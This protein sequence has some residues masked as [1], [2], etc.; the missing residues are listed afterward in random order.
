MSPRKTK[1]DVLDYLNEIFGSD[2]TDEFSLVIH[3][4]TNKSWGQL[5]ELVGD[6]QA[7]VSCDAPGQIK[8]T[9]DSVVRALFQNGK[10][11]YYTANMQYI[12]ASYAAHNP[13][14]CALVSNV[15]INLKV[16][17]N[18]ATGTPVLVEVT[19]G[20]Y[21]DFW[22]STRVGAESLGLVEDGNIWRLP[23]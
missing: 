22:P 7:L 19:S 17:D 13:L 4:S 6:I 15:A 5:Y 10:R 11:F 12:G 9:S 16:A 18:V 1:Q 3:R 2:V 23:T 20:K 14:P 21:V 8:L